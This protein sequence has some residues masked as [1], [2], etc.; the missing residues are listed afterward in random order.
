MYDIE[1]GY[2]ISWGGISY[3][4]NVTMKP[5]ADEI[6]LKGCYVIHTSGASQQAV[7]ALPDAMW[8]P[9]TL[10]SPPLHI[11]PHFL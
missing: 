6:A 4:F 7:V 3:P 10:H 2:T 11:A 9:V 8:E 5:C 1:R